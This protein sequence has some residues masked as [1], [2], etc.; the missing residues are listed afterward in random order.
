MA[1]VK[2]WLK[3]I[4][5]TDWIAIILLVIGAFGF[6]VLPYFVTQTNWLNKN[7]VS[8]GKP[9]E[10]G[11]MIGGIVGPFIGLIS[12]SLV[13]LTIREQIRANKLV[14]A[15]FK[16]EEITRYEKVIF[17]EVIKDV[18]D[19]VE[20]IK[21]IKGTSFTEPFQNL[22][23]DEKISKITYASIFDEGNLSFEFKDNSEILV[24]KTLFRRFVESLEL[25]CS[26]IKHDK[27]F[28][29]IL[30]LKNDKVY[31]FFES[32]LKRLEKINVQIDKYE[33][34]NLCQLKFSVMFDY[35]KRYI[36]LVDKI[37]STH[38]A[39]SPRLDIF[40]N[41]KVFFEIVNFLN[42]YKVLMRDIE[43][44]QS[45][46][47]P[48]R[49]KASYV[50]VGKQLVDYNREEK[51]KVEKLEENKSSLN[52]FLEEFYNKEIIVKETFL[53]YHNSL[54]QKIRSKYPNSGKII[55]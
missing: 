36:L 49:S 26:N 41:Y 1:K 50:Y 31:L 21:N 24:F 48:I 43:N 9:N 30:E 47:S 17:D 54:S 20:E 5:V 10:I 22:S 40:E 44:S 25:F 38:E 4:T 11:D 6:C 51:S 16:N 28:Y 18:N 32:S 37:K 19:V 42:K 35:F 27:A 45:Q 8:F 12:A 52:Q 15:Q 34:S 39:Q 3:K 53:E 55:D 33:N 29:K 46:I 2:K 13:Y 14:Q 7:N 23:N